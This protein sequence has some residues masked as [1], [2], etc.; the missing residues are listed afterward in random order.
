MFAFVLIE[1][2]SHL[3]CEGMN[4]LGLRAIFKKM[5]RAYIAWYPTLCSAPGLHFSRT[6][7]DRNRFGNGIRSNISGIIRSR[8]LA[9]IGFAE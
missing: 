3:A 6:S 8:M 9:H 2:I 4:R 1:E 5:P 7:A